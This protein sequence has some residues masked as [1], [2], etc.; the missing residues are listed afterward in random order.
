MNHYGSF[1]DNKCAD[2]CKSND[3]KRIC[4]DVNGHCT[5]GCTDGF[6]GN[7]CDDTCS[8]QCVNSTCN[9]ITAECLHGCIDGY[10]GLKCDLVLAIK[11][12][13]SEEKEKKPINVIVASAGAGLAVIVL[14][15][16]LVIYANPFKPKQEASGD[17]GKEYDTAIDGEQKYLLLTLAILRSDNIIGV[18]R[19]KGFSAADGHVLYNTA[20]GSKFQTML[21][22]NN[23]YAVF[24][25]N[26]VDNH[27]AFK[28]K[29]NTLYDNNRR[30]KKMQP[31]NNDYEFGSE[32]CE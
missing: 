21:Q 24:K 5:F 12:A 25:S 6:H 7:T 8:H 2:T 9:Q 26:N 20:E 22:P 10:E 18:E 4:D 13:E 3:S 14:L 31:V 29:A 11:R 17:A 19:T 30:E 15:V 27:E 23:D 1:C 16:I 32:D 28:A